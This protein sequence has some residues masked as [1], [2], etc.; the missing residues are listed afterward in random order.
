[1]QEIIKET[2]LTMH[3]Q[4]L[5]KVLVKNDLFSCKVVH[6]Q[7][8][9]PLNKRQRRKWYDLYGEWNVEQWKMVLFSDECAF[10][11]QKAQGNLRVIREKRQGYNPAYTKP[12]FKQVGT[13][14]HVWGIISKRGVGPLIFLDSTV[15]KDTYME[16][17]DD[18][19]IDYI[20]ELEHHYGQEFIFQHDNAPAHDAIQING[21]EYEHESVIGW[22]QEC[23]I[24]RLYHP[25]NSPDLNAIENLWDIVDNGLRKQY[26]TTDISEMKK[27]IEKEWYAIPQETVLN[28]Y[29]SMPRRAVQLKQNKY[30][31][32]DY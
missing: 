26:G 18:V 3:H 10:K 8:V 12:R 23:Q 17:L 28:L 19:L 24:Q 25:G 27:R 7:Y 1:M 14:I 30:F 29:R 9:S 31:P 6:T 32:I 4:T 15:T 22:F 11:L 16:L 20:E 13:K 2:G 21:R 5:R